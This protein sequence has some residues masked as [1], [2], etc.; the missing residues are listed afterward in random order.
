MLFKTRH[1]SWICLWLSC[2]LS[3]LLPASPLM[4]SWLPDDARCE[5]SDPI[6]GSEEVELGE[7]ALSESHSGSRRLRRER[8]GVRRALLASPN[9]SA[10]LPSLCVQRPMAGEASLWGRCGPQRC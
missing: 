2:V 10:S 8:S 9:A 1:H 4:L 6:D 5:E 3:V 7:V